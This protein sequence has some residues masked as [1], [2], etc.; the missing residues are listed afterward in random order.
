[1]SIAGPGGRDIASLRRRTLGRLIDAGVVGIPTLLA[2][3][4][5]A[6]VYF[7]YRRWRGGGDEAEFPFGEHGFTPFRRLAQSSGWSVA[8]RFGSVPIDVRMRNSRSPGDRAMGLRRVDARTGG[9]VS[10]R[11]A[12]IQT[13]VEAAAAELNRLAQRPFEERRRV[14]LAEVSEARRYHEGDREAQ[15]RAMA[16]VLKRYRHRPWGGACSRG[17]LGVIPL[18]LPALWSR[19]NQSL[20]EWIAG[21]VVV[22]DRAT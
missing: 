4:A 7:A 8:F 5:G 10:V 19:R 1:V 21:I 6:G 18:Q 22:R 11:S 2:G 9:P 17:L 12:V 15:H 13:T 14:V 20:P 3:A 16:E